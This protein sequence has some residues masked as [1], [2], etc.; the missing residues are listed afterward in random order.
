MR[1][2][3]HTGPKKRISKTIEIPCFEFTQ[4]KYRLYAFVLDAKTAWKMFR[5][6]G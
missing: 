6:A 3:T 1:K 2:I 4:G 5:L